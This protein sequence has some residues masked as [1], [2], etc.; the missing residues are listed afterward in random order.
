MCP[1]PDAGFPAVTPSRPAD[2]CPGILRLH[3][4]ADGHLARVRLPGGIVRAEGLRA[5]AEIASRGN[6]VVELTGRAGLQVRGLA[7][8]D[9]P[10]TADVLRRGGLLPSPAH[11]RVRNVMAPPAGGRLPGALV[12]TDALVA[13]LD[14]GLCADAALAQLPGRVLFLVDDGGGG[15]DRRRADIALV[16]VAG[17]ARMALVLD[18]R[19]TTLAASPGEAP[20]LALDAA[21]AF[22]ALLRETGDGAWRVSEVPDGA[23]RVAAGLGGAVDIAAV[24]GIGSPGASGGGPPAGVAAQTDGRVAVTAVVPL[25]R[26]D[27]RA[28]RGLAGL[29]RGPDATLRVSPSRTL[30]LVDVPTQ[31]ADAT[32][33]ALRRLGLVTA[34]DS[35]WEGLSACAGLGACA[36]ARV[37]VRAA[38]ERRVPARAGRGRRPAAEHWA[39]CERGCGRPTDRATVVRWVAGAIDVE[40]DGTTG[41]VATVDDAL[42]LLADGARP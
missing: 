12:R 15:L 24:L 40:R 34:S 13:A 20:R 4:A 26:V 16:P 33:V 9:A 36:S 21:R 30:T 42:N 27:G 32:L 10:W 39:A 25:G 37:D 31:D 35:G 11:D 3:A 41:V 2:R 5:V 19:P 18:G 6:D 38:A 14:A 28:L 22:L 8:D 23:A 29:L 17:G 7:A 1:S